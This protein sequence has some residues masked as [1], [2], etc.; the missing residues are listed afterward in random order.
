MQVS[1]EQS[2]ASRENQLGLSLHGHQPLLFKG[3]KAEILSLLQAHKGEWVPC[4]ALADKALQYSA[5]LKELRDA[6]Y[7]IDNRKTRVAGKVHGAFRLV[8]SPG[9]EVQQ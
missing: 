5:R 1:H 7:T 4:Y 3:Q 8:S 9:E 6:G 2:Q